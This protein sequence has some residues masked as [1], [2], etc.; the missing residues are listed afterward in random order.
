[1]FKKSIKA[2]QNGLYS[3]LR[4][5]KSAAE[6]QEEKLVKARAEFEEWAANKDK[7]YRKRAFTKYA[8]GSYKDKKGNTHIVEGWADPRGSFAAAEVIPP[9]SDSGSCGGGE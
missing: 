6:F 7:E 4:P 2:L 8:R 3:I 9:S 5:R 1:M